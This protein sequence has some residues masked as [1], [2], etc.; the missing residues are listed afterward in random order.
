MTLNDHLLKA[1]FSAT[2][3]EEASPRHA[4]DRA[5]V[6]ED[7]KEAVALSFMD[8]V[9]LSYAVKEMLLQNPAIPDQTAEEFLETVGIR[10]PSQEQFWLALVPFEGSTTLHRA[11]V[12]DIV[13]EAK[14]VCPICPQKPYISRLEWA[15]AALAEKYRV[16]I[17][18]DSFNKIVERAVDSPDEGLRERLRE[19]F[20]QN[21]DIADGIREGW[22][23]LEQGDIPERWVL[24]IRHAAIGL[25]SGVFINNGDDCQLESVIAGKPTDWVSTKQI[26]AL[27]YAAQSLSAERAKASPLRLRAAPNRG[28]TEGAITR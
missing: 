15:E 16:V 9:A 24:R 23:T 3:K 8:E 28:V 20:R 10:Q 25:H 18:A 12:E 26:P 19:V 27:I 17:I 6:R 1:Y 7:L 2:L 22:V 4:R 13:L 21:V 5:A 14:N 11:T